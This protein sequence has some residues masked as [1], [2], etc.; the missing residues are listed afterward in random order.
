MEAHNASLS[1]AS[2]NFTASHSRVFAST[3][4]QEDGNEILERA[5]QHLGTEDMMVTIQANDD[6][7]QPIGDKVVK[8]IQRAPENAPEK[9]RG[10]LVCQDI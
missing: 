7:G 3:T 6:D 4:N 10:R 8:H 5:V 2:Y 1:G 9:F